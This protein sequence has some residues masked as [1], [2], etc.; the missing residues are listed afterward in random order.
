MTYLPFSFSPFQLDVCMSV[1]LDRVGIHLP[2]LANWFK[3]GRRRFNG[4]VSMAA[5]ALV[6]R[7]HCTLTAKHFV[8]LSLTVGP[9]LPSLQDV[10]S[11]V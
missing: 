2:F 7:A 3:G 9:Q 5:L 11:V 8:R 6:K 4:Y 1:K 10:I